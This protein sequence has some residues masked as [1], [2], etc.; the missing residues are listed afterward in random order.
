[1]RLDAIRDLEKSDDGAAKERLAHFLTD[2]ELQIRV[3][4]TIALIKKG[5]EQL[6][7]QVIAGL[8]HEQVDVAI[9]AALIL[10]RLKEEKAIPSLIEAFKTNDVALGAA[11][12]WAL[13]QCKSCWLSFLSC[14]L[15][16]FSCRRSFFLQSRCFF[17]L[18][19]CCTFFLQCCRLLFG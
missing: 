18:S 17:L 8:F 13:G 4:A 9:G 2:G 10:G 14:W 6:F 5:E 12:A 7:E 15:F 19:C 3:R 11:V 16:L 1:M